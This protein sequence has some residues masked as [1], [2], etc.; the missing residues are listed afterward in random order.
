AHLERS[1]VAAWVLLP[2]GT[3]LRPREAFAHLKGPNAPVA[4]EVQLCFLDAA[5]DQALGPVLEG[6]G[7][8]LDPD[9]L[10]TWFSSALWPH[11]T[12]G[13]PD[14]ET[15]PVDPGQTPLGSAP[16]RPD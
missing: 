4:V 8:A 2:D 6:A 15:A 1:D 5:Q 3:R 13:W 16:G 14:P 10:D 12:L 11:S 9:V 7:L